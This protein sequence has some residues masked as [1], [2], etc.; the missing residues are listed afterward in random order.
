[1]NMNLIGDQ[2]H[3]NISEGTL[4]FTQKGLNNQSSKA[5]DTDKGGGDKS[6]KPLNNKSQERM[7]MMS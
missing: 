3:L 2:N 5:D 4:I 6:T 7:S 1:M